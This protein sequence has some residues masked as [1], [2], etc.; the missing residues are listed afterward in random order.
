M[1]A[2]DIDT[3][4]IRTSVHDN[5][6]KPREAVT[7]PCKYKAG[8]LLGK[9]TYAEV[10]EM[11]HISSGMMY[12]GKMIRRDRMRGN[13]KLVKREIE[14]LKLVSRK[15]PNVL[16]LVDH[17]ETQNNSYLIMEL[18]Q[19][20][21]L[22]DYI[23][24][25]GSLHETE[26]AHVMRQIV[27]GVCF[28][29]AHG[30]VHRD[31]K[32]ENCLVCTDEFGAPVSVAIADFG[33]A[34]FVPDNG[35]RL[36]TNV[37][38]TPGYMAPEMIQRSGHGK[39]VDMWAVG[40]MTYFA[41]SGVNPFHQAHQRAEL[42]A[43]I[44]CNYSFSPAQRWCAVSPVARDFISSLL[45]ANPAHRMTAKQALEHPWLR[46]CHADPVRLTSSMLNACS[47]IIDMHSKIYTAAD[48][49]CT[50]KKHSTASPQNTAPTKPQQ[51]T[52]ELPRS[53]AELPRSTAELPRSTAELPRS[54]A[55]RG[56]TSIENQL[57]N[58]QLRHPGSHQNSPSV[59]PQPSAAMETTAEV[60]REFTPTS[61]FP[62]PIPTDILS[63][64]SA[65][66]NGQGPL[67]YSS[68]E[69]SVDNGDFGSG[70][71][72]KLMMLQRELAA[73]QP[74]QIPVGGNGQLGTNWM[75]TPATSASNLASLVSRAPIPR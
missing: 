47:A 2:M 21:E 13:T 66:S 75:I 45:V 52:A 67:G 49:C 15:H 58:F 53:T 28:L 35:S 40:I 8:R 10:K 17:F 44:N 41:L 62:G 55:E 27:E 43:I 57:A 73:Q 54:T 3:K 16:T 25:R 71:L 38:G 19:G 31:L 64:L 22:F 20:G 23:H 51:P 72:A 6:Q 30:I 24:R 12:A 4:N 65:G 18:C 50:A 61:K 39:P 14:I 69:T 34:H 36:L 26:A 60:D 9:G 5:T 56:A 74:P 32:T 33:M 48:E 1:A 63:H 7:I 59:S 29:H 11:V 68:E 37:C 42:Q 46:G 70:G